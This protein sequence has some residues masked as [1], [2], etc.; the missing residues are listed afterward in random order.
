MKKVTVF[1]HFGFGQDLANGQTIKTKIVTAEIEKC[2]GVEQVEKIDTVGG[3]K[4]L[5]K[6]FF[7]CVKALKRSRNVIILP[8]HNGVKFFVPVLTFF[9][10]FFKRKLFY[11]VIGGWLSDYL[12]DRKGLEK[13]LKKF[14]C[15][16]VETS[17]MKQALEKRGFKNIKVMPN[18]KE[19]DILSKDQMLKEAEFPLKLCT[20]SR[21]NRQKGI[22]DAVMAVEKINESYGKEILL[23]DIYGNIDAG[24]NDWFESLQKNFKPFV[25]YGGV[26]DFN[27]SVCVLKNYYALLFPTKYYTEGVPGTIIDAY[28]AGVPVI[29]SKWESFEDVVDDGVTGIGYEFDNF[30]KLVQSIEIAVEN[31]EK[32]LE[33]KINCLDKAKEFSPEGV[34]RC[35]ISEL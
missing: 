5:P 22:E 4:A 16:F 35:L 11:V 19:L 27:N 14:N 10:K 34:L 2:V 1:G 13:K 26:V 6:L 18:C 25:K 31:K 21:V 3:V 7:K 29:S 9:N 12:N 28:A 15:I 17:V 32:W 33:M 23:L 20:F 8:A 30:S 24:E